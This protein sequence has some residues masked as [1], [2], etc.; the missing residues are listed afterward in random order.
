VKRFYQIFDASWLMNPRGLWYANHIP[1]FIEEVKLYIADETLK[2]IETHLSKPEKEASARTGRRM[3]AKYMGQK[4][5][6]R[7]T[8]ASVPLAPLFPL[9]N[10]R[11]DSSVD[12]KLLGLA[13]N[14]T[15]EDSA[16]FA[17][18]LTWDGGIQ[19]EASLMHAQTGL[20]I[21]TAATLNQFLQ[22]IGGTRVRDDNPRHLL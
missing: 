16:A 5:Y 22:F 17:F 7:I 12:K 20:P 2:E 18:I 21:F 4:G 14:L 6:T 3:V 13:Y 1:G 19:T 10:L 8:L 15:A 11:A 9:N